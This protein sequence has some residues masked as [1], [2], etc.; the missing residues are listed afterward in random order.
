LKIDKG[1]FSI[2]IDEPNS[3][4]NLIDLKQGWDFDLEKRDNFIACRI[5]KASRAYFYSEPN[6]STRLKIYM[7]K[8]D[9]ILIKG[10]KDSWL[11]V[12]YVN[13]NGV[14]RIGWIKQ[15]MIRSGM[16]L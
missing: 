13:R 9:P 3:C 11:N 12:A 5:I 1:E 8:D 16:P 4:Q 2:Q 15:E 6:D 7:I 10:V 14:V